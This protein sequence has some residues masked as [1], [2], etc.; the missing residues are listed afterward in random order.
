MN[1]HLLPAGPVLEIL[2]SSAGLVYSAG[3]Y[4]SMECLYLNTS[5]AP[6]HPATTP[7]PLFPANRRHNT[8]LNTHPLNYRHLTAVDSVPQDRAAARRLAVETEQQDIQS[9][10]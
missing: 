5:R 3:S 9:A 4:L 10:E 1:L 8:T 7:H 6:L 2:N